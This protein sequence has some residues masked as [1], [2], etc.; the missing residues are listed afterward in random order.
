MML[1]EDLFETC[2]NLK[3]FKLKGEKLNRLKRLLQT[4]CVESFCLMFLKSQATAPLPAACLL[5]SS[6]LTEVA[7]L[8]LINVSPLIC[9]SIAMQCNYCDR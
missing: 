7:G 3:H 5:P 2:E 1:C 4:D 8:I 6:C 9:V